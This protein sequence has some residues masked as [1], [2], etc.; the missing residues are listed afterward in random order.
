MKLAL[1]FGALAFAL[2]AAAAQA[3]S[4]VFVDQLGQNLLPVATSQ[5]VSIDDVGAMASTAAATISQVRSNYNLGTSST[6]LLVQDGE[7]HRG[8][9]NQFGPGNLGLIVQSG[10]MNGASILQSG[11]G[12]SALIMQSGYRNM[13]SVTQSGNNHSALVAQQGRGNVAIISQR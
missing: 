13:A 9:I 1:T 3:A 10:M 8:S 11:S 5:M 2:S 6:A 4:D 12:N 7:D